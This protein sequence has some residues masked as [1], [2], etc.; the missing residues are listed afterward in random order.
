MSLS[1]FHSHSRSFAWR[2]LQIVRDSKIKAIS[3]Q[4]SAVRPCW[5]AAGFM[6]SVM[7]VIFS[8]RF[9]APRRRQGSCRCGTVLTSFKTALLT[10]RLSLGQAHNASGISWC[11]QRKKLISQFIICYANSCGMIVSVAATG[12]PIEF[13]K[14]YSLCRDI[15]LGVMQSHATDS[16]ATEDTFCKMANV[17]NIKTRESRKYS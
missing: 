13:K 1:L 9:T 15:F 8:R 14:Y 5:R 17:R 16:Y 7:H 10:I 11:P 4:F 2:Q 3:I 6:P 12:R